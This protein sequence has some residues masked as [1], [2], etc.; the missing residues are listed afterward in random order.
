MVLIPRNNKLVV[1]ILICGS[2]QRSDFFRCK[3][4]L[5]SELANKGGF[6]DWDAFYTQIF[7]TQL[8][9]HSFLS[10]WPEHGRIFYFHMRDVTRNEVC[11]VR[12]L[13]IDQVQCILKS[14]YGQ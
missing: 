10:H 11:G 1:G 2:K 7:W 9:P 3:R 5:I 13:S 12:G 8:I 14:L 4:E 6:W